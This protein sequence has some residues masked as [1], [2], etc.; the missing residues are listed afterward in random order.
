MAKGFVVKLNIIVLAA[1]VGG[2]GLAYLAANSF[3]VPSSVKAITE[4]KRQMFVDLMN[5]H[6]VVDSPIYEAKKTLIIDRSKKCE[7]AR[8]LFDFDQM[9]F[10][11]C[12]LSGNGTN[13]DCGPFLPRIGVFVSSMFGDKEAS[14]TRRIMGLLLD[15]L[16]SVSVGQKDEAVDTMERI[17]KICE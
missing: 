8:Y 12:S 11:Y 5:E 6:G 1:V 16:E 4:Y 14:R 15:S 9:E 3:S 13:F 17:K 10:N 2:A 7:K